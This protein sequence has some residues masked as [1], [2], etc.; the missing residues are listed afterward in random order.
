MLQRLL[1]S[2]Q[3]AM[4]LPIDLIELTSWCLSEP[5]AQLL[6]STP[7]NAFFA[8][9]KQTKRVVIREEDG[10]GCWGVLPEEWR[11]FFEGKD[12]VE[13]R[14]E[15]LKALALGESLVRFSTQKDTGKYNA[16][17]I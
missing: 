16:D 15:I 5:L 6:V 3:G 1:T 9:N 2:A 17:V 12:V 8:P 7:V 10:D 14:K 11:L 4:N 13:R